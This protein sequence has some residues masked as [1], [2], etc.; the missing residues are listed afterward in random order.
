VKRYE[1]D[2]IA[3]KAKTLAAMVPGSK[4][5]EAARALADAC[6]EVIDEAVEEEKFDVAR[7]L[8]SK[9][10]AAVRAARDASRAAEAQRKGREIETL[11]RESQKAKEAAKIL[12]SN[13]ADPD[14]SLV[15]GRYL[16]LKGNFEKALPLLSKG[17]DPLLREAADKE[18]AG[19]SKP[20]D[21]ASAA[22]AWWEAAE[23]E[24]GALKDALQGHAMKWYDRALEGL[25]GIRKIQIEKR[26]QGSLEAA[27]RPGT[28]VANRIVLWNMHNGIHNDRGTTKINVMLLNGE[29]E[30]FAARGLKMPWESN[31]DLSLDVA[32]PHVPFTSVRVE[33]T[34]FVGSGG[35][36]AEV[37][38]M[39][40]RT[41]IALGRT[42]KS[43]GKHPAAVHPGA[44]T[45]TDGIT[46]SADYCKGYWA[47]P[48]S[49]PGWAE[50]LFIDTPGKRRTSK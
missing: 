47:L 42:V 8:V 26:M 5:S 32:I 41:N 22:D 33:V 39:Q 29:R 2:G 30:L 4:S 48:N 38:V 34:E 50:V 43:S 17:A 28:V 23:K 20:E 25:S 24:S 9:A 16:L 7:S 6:L 49:T 37:Q 35:G 13:P 45:L 40:G 18:L 11:Q 10:E 15:R 14:A 46:T 44:E 3:L 21:L 19:P 27:K 36:L 1:V 12:E 31:K